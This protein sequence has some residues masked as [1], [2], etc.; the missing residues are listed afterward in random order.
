MQKQLLLAA[1]FL[2]PVAAMAQSP[3][4]ADLFDG[5]VLHE[6][7]ISMKAADWTALKAAYLTDTDFNVD[8]L[9]W[10]GAGNLTASVTNLTMHNRG[11]GSRSPIKPGLHVSFDGVV[12]GQTFL[13][14]PALELKPN[15]Q[16]PSMLHE[17][18]SMLLFNRMGIPSS[19][20]THTRFYVNGEYIGVYLLVE[21]PDAALLSRIF[22]E[23][24]GYL[25][26]YVPG[27]WAGAA[28]G[29]WHF[30]YLGADLD[31]YASATVSTPFSP[32]NHT[33]APDTVTLEKLFRVIN[34]EPDA[35]FVSAMTSEP[36][37]GPLL[38][39]KL[40][41]THIA[42]ETYV[43]DFDCILGDIFG[44]NNFRFYRFVNKQLSQFIPWDKD[45]AFD[46]TQRP[47]LQNA[48][49]NVLM[50]RLMAIPE[51]KNYYFQALVKCSLLAGGA[52]GWMQQE[53]ARE[54]KLIQ[55]AAYDDP[56]KSYLNAG[57]LTPATNAQFD[58][59]VAVVQ[60]F[61]TERTRFV[62]SDVAAQ[63]YQ[64]PTG[65]PALADGGVISAAVLGP[66]AAGGLASIYGSNMGNG[67]NTTVYVNGYA[68]PVFFAS[69][70]QFNIQVP[71]EANGLASFGM[72]VNGVASNIQ[73]ANVN[74]YSPAVFVLSATQAAITH[75]DGSLVSSSNPAAAGETVIVYGTGL[76]PVTGDMVTGK[77][78]SST[79]LQPTSPTQA[80]AKIG[81]INAAVSFSGLTPGF[82]GLY[83][84]NV[85]VPQN[86]Q[87]GASLVITI[88]GG[89]SPA[90]P[91]S[92]R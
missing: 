8:S 80:T 66:V 25:Y 9:Q 7:R 43:A 13:G 57:S 47:V 58:A 35:S 6:V 88:G 18:I 17:R 29:G 52:G 42:V 46:W 37:L 84:V 53:A 67:D 62:L 27:D 30:E 1:A 63:G 82:T 49:Q 14:L 36:Q 41:L 16:D 90:V 34:Q 11:H 76:G 60:G 21:Y 64:F 3:T 77:P 50:R 85:Q 71:W 39:L 65:A 20:E 78:A 5:T 40:F 69:S 55:Q 32:S 54:Y 31:K 59:A 15:T 86:V 56:N 24:T 87:A 61:A 44:A 74:T 4:A 22:N 51:Y 45:N 28:G 89:S 2:M 12:K 72:T 38:D 81:G 19:R 33:N 92:T 75:V 83:Q 26:N 91:I 10:K 23:T 73:T 48:N 79:V 70:G 68:A